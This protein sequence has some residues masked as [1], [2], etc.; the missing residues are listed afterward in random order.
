MKTF[1]HHNA[2]SLKEAATLLSRYGG[3]AKV[4][5]GGTDLLGILRDSCAAEY[6]EAVVNIKNIPR[7]N[8]VKAGVKGLRIGALTT[9]T[10]LL[11]SPAVQKDYPLLAEAV[12]SVASPNLR[13]MA[14]I[15]GNLAQD[16]RCWYYRYPQQIGGPIVCL[17]KGG[18]TC[19]ALTGDNRYHS[20]FGAA[21]ADERR[22]A[23][24]CPAHINIPGY[25]RHVREGRFPEAARVLM[26][27]NPIPAI[28]G[29]VCP[30]FCEPECNRGEF[31][32]PVAIHSVER[33]VGDYILDH[34]GE[35]FAPP[36]VESGR[37]VAVVGSGPAGLAAAFYLRK[38]G[39]GVTVF[40]RM[41]EAGG[42][43]LYSIPPYRLPKEVVRR[44]VRALQSMGIR[45][46][47][48]FTVGG[49]AINRIRSSYDA[50]FLAGGTWKSLKL[51]VPGEEASN[52]FDALDY[53]CRINS[54]QK[55]F[56]GR[57]I[58]VVGGGS[59]AIDAARTARRL[60]SE[61]VHIVCLETRDLSSRDRMPALDREIAA[62]EEEGVV[63]HPS[64][65]IREIVLQDGKAV[66]ISTRRCTSVRELDGTFNP[67]Y[68]DF[69]GTERIAA[70]SIVVAIGQADDQSLNLATSDEVVA[71]PMIFA[72]GDMTTG[73]STVIQAVASA[74]EA[75]REIEAFLGGSRSP[76]ADDSEPEYA[77]SCF[78]NIQRAEAREVPAVDRIRSLDG[79]DVQGLGLAELETEA[80]RCVSCGC[81]AVAP[82][83]LAIALVALDAAILTDKR[84]LEAKSFFTASATCSTVLEPDELIKE[85]RI[86]KPPRGARQSYR[87]FTLRKPIDFAVV[88]VASIITSQ[89]GI[90]SDARITLGAVAPSPLRASAAED[91]LKGKPLTEA[92]AAE[93]ARLALEG[94]MPLSM[95]AYK[96][97]IARVL[98]KRSILGIPD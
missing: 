6:P 27:Y 55:P 24:H 42:M 18:R 86:P 60:G 68:D 34:A 26:R 41:P 5:A 59:V 79:E 69:S 52:V 37:K 38:S 8:F 70:D 7:L 95:N 54:G 28:T 22:C 91:A 12:R 72:G 64:L 76:R 33:G 51:G 9:L 97:E 32:D 53:L 36:E 93:A 40:E 39:H 23:G 35:Y 47:T 58:V 45:F 25:L 62:A 88:S 80:G 73:S 65:G 31:D 90:C 87:K 15:G 82:S 78:E 92:T 21:A 89:R 20:I 48:G 11:H 94:A 71:S 49:E 74:Q 14:T 50:V 46:E 77:A 16:V 30:I 67:T 4:N 43:L 63:V 84:T 2:R 29:R 96:A 66:A 56:L 98:V 83:D 19:S 17:R 1:R 57:S 3:K 81:L 10:D 61:Q 75:F 44:Q 13:N 85:I